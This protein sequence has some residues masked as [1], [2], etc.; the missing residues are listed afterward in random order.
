VVQKKKEKK[1]KKEPIKKKE[2]TTNIG[3]N[4]SQTWTE[5]K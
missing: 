1:K 5:K 4:Q 2:I 3:S